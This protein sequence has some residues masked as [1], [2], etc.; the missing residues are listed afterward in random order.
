MNRTVFLGALAAAGA[1]ALSRLGAAKPAAA[2]GYP[3]RHSDAEWLR[4]L[5]R[6]RYW[7]LRQG[8][9]EQPFSSPLNAERRAGI[10]HCAGCDLR[11][12]DSRTKYDA[13]EGWPSFWDVL[14]NAVRRQADYALVDPRTE[15]HCR[16]CGGHLGHRFDDGP[17]P[18]HLRYCIDGLALRFAPA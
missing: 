13:G 17:P 14:P 18:T 3:V 4:I 11:L 9:T 6:D 12:F 5:G 7:I 8:G 2:A 15:V 1:V 16:Q 10:Y